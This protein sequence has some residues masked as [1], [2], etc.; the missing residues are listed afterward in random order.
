MARLV[1]QDPGNTFWRGISGRISLALGR[2]LYAR[3]EL[4]EAA[5]AAG[6][7]EATAHALLATDS[8]VINWQTDILMP[9]RLLQARLAAEGG[10]HKEA[11]QL[12]RKV[13]SSLGEV[14]ES[15]RHSEAIWS[16]RIKAL[17]LEGNQLYALGQ[18]GGIAAWREA[19][20]V[21]H[22]DAGSTT[23]ITPA[24]LTA[25]AD[26]YQRLGENSE[27]RRIMT[28][29]DAMGYRAPE[30]LSLKKRLA[31]ARTEQAHRVGSHPNP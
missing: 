24:T 27:A 17:L 3:G 20:S 28:R 23:T 10:Q 16:L 12:V 4:A 11:L 19:V 6:K 30:F 7:A 2:V 25:I 18:E 29:L 9:A 15:K 14:P 26:G 1:K 13:T 31:R 22:K 5:R 21:V 8:T